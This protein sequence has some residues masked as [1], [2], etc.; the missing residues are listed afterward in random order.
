[1]SD[2][3]RM[4]VGVPGLPAVPRFVLPIWLARARVPLI[5]AGLVLALLLVAALCA[6]LLAP[7]DPNAQK[8]LARLPDTPDV[9]PQKVD[10]VLESVLLVRFRMA[11]FQRRHVF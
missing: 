10:L 5:A 3:A 1:M 11:R 6:P 9:Y 2:L 7:F 4:S 8:L